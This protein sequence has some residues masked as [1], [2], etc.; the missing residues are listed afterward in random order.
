MNNLHHRCYFEL[1]SGPFAFGSKVPVVAGH[2]R[3][4]SGGRELDTR[5][6]AFLLSLFLLAMASN[7]VL[8]SL[9]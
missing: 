7:L 2:A 8:L 1:D 5:L 3:F 4:P 9:L 6:L